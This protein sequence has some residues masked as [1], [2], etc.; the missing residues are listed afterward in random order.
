MRPGPI[1]PAPRRAGTQPLAH[2]VPIPPGPW[3]D[4]AKRNM[5]VD[6]YLTWNDVP[7]TVPAD[8]RAPICDEPRRRGVIGALSALAARFK[9]EV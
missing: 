1:P 6:T 8:W 3:P 5:K 2:A 9:P 4:R 7:P